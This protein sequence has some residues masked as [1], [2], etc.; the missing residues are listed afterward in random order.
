VVSC[1]AHVIRRRRPGDRSFAWTPSTANVGVAGYHISVNTVPVADILTT[2][3][4]FT[5]LTPGTTYT[6][7]VQAFDLAGNTSAAAS[8]TSGPA[9]GST[10]NQATGLAATA[11]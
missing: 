8:I 7:T 1:D 3:V 5:G 4:N 10:I 11:N 6:V 2:P 9:G